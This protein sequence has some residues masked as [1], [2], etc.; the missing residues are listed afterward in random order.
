M[1]MLFVTCKK[2]Q[3]PF[4]S[5]LDMDLTSVTLGGNRHKCAHCAA[6]GV[7]EQQDHSEGPPRRSADRSLN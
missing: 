6:V 4:A 1:P 2:C 7:Y 5:G 3:K